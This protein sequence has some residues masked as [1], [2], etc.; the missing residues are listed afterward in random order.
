M[1]KLISVLF[2]KKVHNKNKKDTFAEFPVPKVVWNS[3]K[4]SQSSAPP[5]VSCVV[6][7]NPIAT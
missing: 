7:G 2:R 4:W 3:E 6:L 1:R 5:L